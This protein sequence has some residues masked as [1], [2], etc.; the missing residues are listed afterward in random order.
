MLSMKKR[1]FRSRSVHKGAMV[2]LMVVTVVPVGYLPTVEAQGGLAADG[3]A[4][5]GQPL[6]SDLNEVTPA[7]L[8]TAPPEPACDTTRVKAADHPAGL[9]A[10]Y[11]F[12]EGTGTKAGD[13]SGKGNH[14]LIL[15]RAAWTTHGRY[16]TGLSL[17]PEK[18]H[19]EI[20][21][22]P[23]LDLVGANLTL[24]MW[25]SI[26]KTDSDGVILS[27]PWFPHAMQEP[28][29]QYAV[30]YDGNE[31]KTVDFYFGDVTGRKLGPFSMEAL[32]EQ[33][34]HVAFTYNGEFVAGY[35][36]G[37]LKVLKPVK[38]KIPPRKTTLRLGADGTYSQIYS[39]LLDEVRIYNRA[40]TPREIVR[41]MMTPVP[42]TERI[43]PPSQTTGDAHSEGS[44]TQLHEQPQS[45]LSASP[46]RK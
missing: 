1:G 20:Q 26:A 24:S 15:N 45:P 10:A 8:P 29:Y 4:Q 3:Q 35:V 28:Y 12:C 18:S 23:S 11:S 5:E 19:V 33:W 43:Q 32:L 25:V 13:S 38:G 2:L 42:F 46:Q 37:R 34:A 17:Y 27:K 41:D 31:G 36:N 40:L 7:T 22:S 14:G 9:I 6:P 30:E 39:G 44:G 16:G 21:N